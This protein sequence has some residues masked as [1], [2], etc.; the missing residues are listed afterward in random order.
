MCL[1]FKEVAGSQC[2]GCFMLILFQNHQSNV[3]LYLIFPSPLLSIE[4]S[5]AAFARLFFLTAAYADHANAYARNAHVSQ[6]MH[7]PNSETLG[8]RKVTRSNGCSSC[9]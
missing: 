1:D 3:N 6:I 8:T 2:G 7:R 9:V 4:C 5:I